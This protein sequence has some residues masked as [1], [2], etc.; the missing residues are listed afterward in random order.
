M[1][2]L[3][4][5]TKLNLNGPWLLD[6]NSL[7][8]LDKA[9]SENWIKLEGRRVKL[10]NS[11]VKTRR[12]N[13]PENMTSKELKEQL[14]KIKQLSP[15]SHGIKEVRIFFSNDSRFICEDFETAFS[16]RGLVTETPIGFEVILKSGD[17]TCRIEAY[18][19]NQ[20]KIEVTPEELPESQELYMALREWALNYHPA[21]W[22]RLW[23]S[24]AKYRV[25][26]AGLI[27]FV[28]GAYIYLLQ[29]FTYFLASSSTEN[30]INQLLKAGIDQSNLPEAVEL[31]LTTQIE[32][33]TSSW[34]NKISPLI[35][36]L[37][38]ITI[39]LLMIISPIYPKVVL[40]IGK[41]S[42]Y[43]RIWRIW[44]TSVALSIPAFIFFNF[45]SPYIVDF[46]KR[47]L[48]IP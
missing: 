12:A 44:L 23:I 6:S 29:F 32:Q 33:S 17:I 10:L 9:I 42:N 40:G 22:Q 35:L 30:K 3:L 13:L 1:K 11:E 46:V 16:E 34:T 15:H 24:I 27:V 4:F 14:D 26:F 28:T 25:Y 8:D 41:G 48:G 39:F 2:Q 43:I 36:L 19:E 18:L 47:F 45:V 20:L 5:S 38:G 31:L 37:L 7:K 21:Y